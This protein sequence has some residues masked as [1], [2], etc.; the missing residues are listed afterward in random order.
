M[1]NGGDLLKM[2]VQHPTA[3]S[4]VLYGVSGEDSTIMLGGQQNEDNGVVDGGGRLI[5]SK[6]NVPGYVQG[7][8][9]NDMSLPTPEFEFMQK[10]A[11]SPQEAKITVTNINQESYG[12]SGTVVG[13]VTLNA[14]TSTFQMKVTSGLGFTLL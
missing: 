12:G 13:E 3:G 7:T 14:K 2:V 4:A 10:V 9:A 5:I 1:I 8:F 6:K 11:N